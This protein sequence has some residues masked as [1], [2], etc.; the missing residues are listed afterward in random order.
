MST[1]LECPAEWLEMDMFRTVFVLAQ[2][3]FNISVLTR[4]DVDLYF[5]SHSA[6]QTR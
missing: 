5:S 2:S 1:C 4:C 3:C 6:A